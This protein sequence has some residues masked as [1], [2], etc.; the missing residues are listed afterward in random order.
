[1]RGLFHPAFLHPP[2][3]DPGVWV[4]MPDEGRALLLD[5]PALTHVTHRKLL[6]VA[7]AVVTHTHMD[8]FVGF[9]HLL[10]IALRREDLLTVTGPEGFLSSVR[11]R[12]AAYAWNLIASYPVRLRVQEVAGAVLRAEEYSG[13]SEM[14]PEP[15]PDVPFTGTVHAE[16]AFRVDVATLDH[17]LPVLGIAVR[18]V[19]HLAV[20]RD[21]L[22]RRGLV[23]GPWLARLKDAIRRGEAGDTPI[24]AERDDGTSVTLSLGEIG[25]EVVRRGP[26]QA[27]GYLTDLAGTEVNLARA[28][29]LVRDVDLLLCEAAFLDA[30]RD[31]ASERH[32]LTAAQAGRLA[33]DA[34]AKRLA[35][36]HLSP[37]YEGRERDLFDE[38]AEAFG[39]P[40]LEM[41]VVPA[42]TIRA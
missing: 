20:D 30:D 18:E 4:D 29:E 1:M 7:H 31:L 27:L 24:A 11:G 33:R 16:R 25:P 26:G 37:R 19:E 38:A 36:F 34:G 32:H 28:A 8:H 15:L 12:V 10:R 21:R 14:R 17:G 23:P 35:I 39:A 42:A 13:A 22:D 41:P 5:L 6:R 9:D 40:T 3:G 2:T